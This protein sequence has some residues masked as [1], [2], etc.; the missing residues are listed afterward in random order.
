VLDDVRTAAYFSAVTFSAVGYG[1]VTLH[2]PW[3]LLSGLEAANGVILFGWST[4]LVFAGVRQVV[5]E[6]RPQGHRA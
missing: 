4:S 6:D 5:V 3:R 1:D 2:N